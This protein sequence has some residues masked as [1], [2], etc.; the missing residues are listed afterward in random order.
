[1]SFRLNTAESLSLLSTEDD[2]I[3][4]ALDERRLE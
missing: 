2:L 3:S 4:N 1:M